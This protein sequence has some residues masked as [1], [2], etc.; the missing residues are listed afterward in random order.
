MRWAVIPNKNRMIMEF[1]VASAA[2]FDA[3]AFVV[4]SS[5]EMVECATDAVLCSG[6]AMTPAD[7]GTSFGQGGTR[8]FDTDYVLVAIAGPGR[9][10]LMTETDDTAPAATNLGVDYGV[11]LESDGTFSID[12]GETTNT[13]VVVTG[14]DLI[15]NLWEV[16]V[17]AAKAELGGTYV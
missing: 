4:L 8:Q 11:L 3:G 12:D 1:P 9:T 7:G 2:T 10:F 16:E 14:I 5:G 13:L 6:V 17:I 15:R